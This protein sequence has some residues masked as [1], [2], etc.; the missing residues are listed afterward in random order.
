MRKRTMRVFKPFDGGSLVS[1][2]FGRL[3][4]RL[5]PRR[6]RRPRLRREKRQ[7]QVRGRRITPMW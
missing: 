7:R 2:P 5:A 6:Q 3:R 1:V 4:R